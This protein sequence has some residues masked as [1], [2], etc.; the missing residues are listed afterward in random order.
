MAESTAACVD[1]EFNVIEHLGPGQIAPARCHGSGGRVNGRQQQATDIAVAGG[2]ATSLGCLSGARVITS[3][4]WIGLQK[5]RGT[6]EFGSLNMQLA[7]G[8][9]A[10][11]SCQRNLW[12]QDER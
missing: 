7:P 10:C 1:V 3:L 6:T 11:A 2:H 4:R 5:R 12:V 9:I 8:C